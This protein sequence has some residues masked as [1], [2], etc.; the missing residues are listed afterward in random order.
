MGERDIDKYFKDELKGYSKDVD[1][2]ALWSALDLDKKRKK[3]GFFVWS[4]S[5]VLVAILVL[6]YFVFDENNLYQESVQSAKETLVV[7]NESSELPPNL[8]VS[9]SNRSKGNLEN[10][11]P[12]NLIEETQIHENIVKHSTQKSIDVT[13][14]K[15]AEFSNRNTTGFDYSN[16]SDQTVVSI[17]TGNG[18]YARLDSES[19][20]IDQT[21]ISMNGSMPLSNPNIPSELKLIN[22]LEIKFAQ[23]F[24]IVERSVSEPSLVERDL[25][26][27]NSNR[28]LRLNIYSG[29]YNVART[30]TTQNMGLEQFLSRKEES[31]SPLELISI[32]VQLRYDI[33]SLYVKAGIEF[34]SLNNKFEYEQNSVVDTVPTSGIV[35]VI[36]D[37]EGNSFNQV[38]T[39]YEENSVTSNWTHYNSHRLF[40]MP[41]SIGYEKRISKWSFSIEAQSQLNFHHSYSGKRLDQE[42]NV[43]DN[44]S[45][46]NKSLKLGLGAAVGLR[47]EYSNTTS[48]YLSPSYF[49]Y[50]DSFAHESQNYSEKYRLFGL[51]IGLSY[52]LF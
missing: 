11:L 39:V 15:S 9:T 19:V 20:K 13:Q 30:L 22:S 32:G 23:P 1:T 41:L 51:Q 8:A 36:I 34:Q 45:D 25:L 43:T 37:S 4:T 21:N 40:N 2:N 49:S 28:A 38:G 14:S 48:I 24:T 10:I 26:N 27:N 50:L 3:R 35:G 7:Q 16:D 46:V 12:L 44:S 42:G 33:G 31:E 29:V 47:Y 6:V 5:L 18:R 52:K 17:N